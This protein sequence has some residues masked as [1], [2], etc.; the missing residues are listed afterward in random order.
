[1]NTTS[2]VKSSAKRV[3]NRQVRNSRAELCCNVARQFE[4]AGEFDAA[5]RA[6]IEF[7]PEQQSPPDIEGLEPQT[8]GEV[9]LRAGVILGWIGATRQENIPQ[10]T[11]K[12]LITRAIEIFESQNQIEKAA[13][14][15]SDLA[16]CYVREGAFDEARI[17]VAEALRVI[18]ENSDLKA[19]ILIRSGVTEFGARRFKA[20]IEFYNEAAPLV[21]RSEDHSLK[22]SFHSQMG[23][24]YNRLANGGNKSYREKALIEFAAA[25]HHFE[26]AG[27]TR[28]VA[29]TENN[30]AFAS[31]N[32]GNLTLAHKHLDRACELL[33]EIKDRV[34]LAQVNDSRARV[35]LAEGRINE[36]EQS[37]RAAVKTLEKSDKQYALAEVLITHGVALARLG[38]F[39][40]AKA[41]FVQAMGIAETAGDSNHAGQASL[42]IIEELSDHTPAYEV[43]AIYKSAVNFLKDSQDP[44]AEKRLIACADRVIASLRDPQD[45]SRL[46]VPRSGKGISFKAE[47]LKREKKIIERALRDSHGSVTQAARLL[48]FKHHQNLISL[49]NNQHQD[50]LSRRSTIR[51]RRR[52]LLSEVRK[53]N[54]APGRRK[55]QMSILHA[56]SNRSIARL[57]ADIVLPE[58]WRLEVCADGNRAL[59]KLSGK[60]HY[61]LLMV[62]S[63]LEGLESLELIQ[64]ARRMMHR[65]RMPIVMLSD[66]DCETEAWR[67]GVDAF[68][69]L[70]AQLAELT[71]MIVRL[72]EINSAND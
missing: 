1:M 26:K 60:R 51:K 33:A 6:L 41:R 64:L 49:I 72:L 68:L 12:N 34:H 53:P 48:G 43:A 10:E 44:T 54:S 30:L 40:Q 62:D 55:S 69:K 18:A 67:V 35:F 66:R 28:Y 2:Q 5:Y 61:D 37:A 52:P 50:L 23:L 15:R 13:E 45:E 27:H 46:I 47:I 7:W 14:A 9:I 36:A 3:N 19:V 22:G 31:L 65:R 21:E 17:N 39:R 4:K 38:E 20:A 29:L 56:E 58:N 70:P 71:S 8:A 25:S 59:Q 11:A 16:L 42:S 32:S 57:V 63:D 24:A